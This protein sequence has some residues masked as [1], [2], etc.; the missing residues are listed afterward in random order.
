[1]TIQVPDDLV[2]RLWATKKWKT[3]LSEKLWALQLS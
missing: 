3:L 1:M 2:V